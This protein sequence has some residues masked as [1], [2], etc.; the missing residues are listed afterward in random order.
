MAERMLL[1]F[2]LWFAGSFF[3]VL[4]PVL[5]TLQDSSATTKIASWVLFI[6]YVVSATGFLVRR[7]RYLRGW[8]AHRRS[9]KQG[10]G[11]DAAYVPLQNMS[12]V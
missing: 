7:V 1:P 12:E 10:D 9:R 5:C 2:V 8:D 3:F 6:V 4:F 11:T